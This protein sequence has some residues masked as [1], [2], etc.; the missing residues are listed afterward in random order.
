MR[1]LLIPEFL[2]KALSTIEFSTKALSIKARSIKEF[3]I[4]ELVMLELAIIAFF[5]GIKE[6]CCGV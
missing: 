2:I 5:Q 4:L 3:F 6:I 1:V